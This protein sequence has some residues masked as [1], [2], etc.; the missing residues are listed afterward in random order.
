[1]TTLA[2]TYAIRVAGHLDDH[3]AARLGGAGLRWE[4]DGSTTVLL[5]AADQTQLHGVLAA[6]RDI[7]AELVEIRVLDAGG[8]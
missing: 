3:W 5:P 2:R 6:L 8:G 7:G 4:P 1:M